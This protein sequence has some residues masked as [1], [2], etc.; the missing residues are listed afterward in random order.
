MVTPIIFYKLNFIF[1]EDSKEL[2]KEACSVPVKKFDW[3]I[4]KSLIA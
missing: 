2:E 3:V 4:Q 1:D